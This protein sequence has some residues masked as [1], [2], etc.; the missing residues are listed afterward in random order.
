MYGMYVSTCCMHVHSVFCLLGV[1]LD[2]G[3]STWSIWTMGCLLGV[4]LDDESSTWSVS[5]RW[6]EGGLTF[7]L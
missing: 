3:S 6:V 2:D 4:Y 1:Y 5:G 7:D